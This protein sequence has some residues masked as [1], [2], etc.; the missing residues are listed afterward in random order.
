MKRGTLKDRIAA[1]SVIVSTNPV[2]KLYA[3]DGLLQFAANPNARMAQ[4]AA[5][6]LEDLFLST[7]LPPN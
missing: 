7:L 4:M 6:A 1:M 5:E 2:H 3:L